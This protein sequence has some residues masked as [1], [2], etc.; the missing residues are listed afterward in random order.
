MA[1]V[2]RSKVWL[3]V[4]GLVINHIGEWLV[5]KKRYGGL[6]GKWSLPDGFV[7]PGET[8]DQAV[9]REVQEETGIEIMV[10]GLI[11]FRTGVI[12]GDM[13]DNMAIFICSTTHFEQLLVPQ[14]KEVYEARWMS[15]ITLSQDPHVSVMIHEMTK[16][17][18][19]AAIQVNEGINPGDVFGYTSYKLFF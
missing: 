6:E 10:Q 9:V 12:R 7:E 15:P 19:G 16:K 17:T 18:L 11:G 8:M 3:C 1:K 13:S 14:L 4:A 5:V 2:E